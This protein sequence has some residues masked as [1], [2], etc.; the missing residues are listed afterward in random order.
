[1]NVT[2]KALWALF[3]VAAWIPA[4]GQQPGEIVEIHVNRIKPA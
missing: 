1:M 3:T 4:L 2:R